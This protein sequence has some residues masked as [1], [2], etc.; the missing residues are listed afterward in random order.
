ML[1]TLPSILTAPAQAATAALSGKTAHLDAAAGAGFARLMQQHTAPAPA[2][3]AE[4]RPNP[5]TAR[6]PSAAASPPPST[7]DAGK[8]RAERAQD[9]APSSL[10]ERSTAAA[11]AAG[12]ADP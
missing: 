4:N 10:A 2:R 7:D 12:A 6:P 1:K 9:N 3:P 5:D 11:G 8:R